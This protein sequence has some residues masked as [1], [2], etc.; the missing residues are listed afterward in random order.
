M[1]E[2]ARYYQ[3]VF[4][5]LKDSQKF[6]RYVELLRPIV[7]RY[8]GALER[9]LAPDTVHAEGIRKPDVINVVHY[10]SKAA[11]MS[12]QADAEFQ[13]IVHLRSESIEMMSVQG[14]PMAG[15][16]TG[17]DLEKRRYVLDFARYAKG[18]DAYKSY[19]E[20]AEALMGPHGYHVERVLAPD[21]VTD[22][23][24]KPDIVKVAYFD[25]AA[26]MANVHANPAHRRIETEF[27]PEAVQQSVWVFGSVHP[28]SL[29]IPK[30]Q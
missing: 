8:G 12:F 11:F 23:P 3:V 14:F 9:M 29:I 17:T 2:H 5:W 22:F 27:Y 4:I 26:D 1:R 10:E 18:A 30:T 25:D 13:R 15:S 21:S 20:Q 16:P 6:G 24:F 28:A 19:Q 7:G